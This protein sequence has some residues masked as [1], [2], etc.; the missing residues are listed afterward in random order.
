MAIGD[1]GQY[2]FGPDRLDGILMLEYLESIWPELERREFRRRALKVVAF[3]LP[4]AVLILA[5]W[6]L[7]E[8]GVKP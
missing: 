5:L 1:L 6:V 2:F 3:V 4:V 8:N 7:A